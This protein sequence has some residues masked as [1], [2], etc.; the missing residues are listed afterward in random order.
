MGDESRGMSI[1]HIVSASSS[2]KGTALAHH[3]EQWVMIAGP[4]GLGEPEDSTFWVHWPDISQVWWYHSPIRVLGLNLSLF[5]ALLTGDMSLSVMP[6]KVSDFHSSLKLVINHSQ[7]FFL[8]YVDCTQKQPSD[9]KFLIVTTSLVSLKCL[10]YC[11]H[12]CPVPIHHGGRLAVSLLQHAMDC[13]CFTCRQWW[14]S[15]CQLQNLTV[16]L[17]PRMT[18]EA[19]SLDWVP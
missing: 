15:L 4:D 12:Q 3:R 8:K 2:S 14:G 13:E 1:C 17:L 19:S 16:T 11:S 6:R 9:S 18:S 5:C 7:P 10:W